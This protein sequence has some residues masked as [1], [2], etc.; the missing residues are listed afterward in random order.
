MKRID[1]LY[2]INEVYMFYDFFCFMYNYFVNVVFVFCL[3][4]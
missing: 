4:K 3:V 1:C 2:I